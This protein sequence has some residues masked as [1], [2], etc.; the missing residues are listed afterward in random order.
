ML[1]ILK[2]NQKIKRKRAC[3]ST[4]D[5]KQDSESLHNL[6]SCR[7]LEM[8]DISRTAIICLSNPKHPNHP[9][10]QPHK[11]V[12]LLGVLCPGSPAHVYGYP[13]AYHTNWAVS[14]VLVVLYIPGYPW[15]YYQAMSCVL[16]ALYISGYLWLSLGIPRYMGCVLFPS[17]PEHSRIFLCIIR[18][19]L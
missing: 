17:S 2:F 11:T 1:W 4:V 3:L 14:C 7:P 13:W 16:V 10:N 15:V 9:G 19:C 18:G 8:R 5:Q 12:T 6:M